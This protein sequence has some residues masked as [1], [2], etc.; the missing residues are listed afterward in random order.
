MPLHAVHHDVEARLARE[1]DE[2]RQ[3]VDGRGADQRAV[4]LEQRPQVEDADVVEAEGGDLGQVLAGA[5]RVEV[6]P[7]VEPA[8]AGRVVDA[9]AGRGNGILLASPTLEG[10]GLVLAECINHHGR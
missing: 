1:V 9:E 8:A 10:R 5:R 7:G 6:L 3:L 2:V 4:G